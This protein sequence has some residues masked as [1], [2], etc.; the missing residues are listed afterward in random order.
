M[1]NDILKVSDK[2]VLIAGPITSYSYE[3][4]YTFTSQGASI[5]FLTPDTDKARRICDTLNDSRE[6]YKNYGRAQASAL[7]SVSADLD[8]CV[9]AAIQTI[10]GLDIYVDALNFFETTN[11]PVE[12]PSAIYAKITTILTERQRGKIVLLLDASLKQI[13]PTAESIAFRQNS[14][15][16]LNE[17]RPYLLTKNIVAH[18]LHITLSEDS[19]LFLNPQRTINESLKSINEANNLNLKITKPDNISKALIAAASDLMTAVLPCDLIL[20]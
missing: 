4:G 12:T 3:I 8:K 2:R 18:S 11:V 20:Y 9:A 7:T 6:I 17:Q 1:P 16:W 5:C 14:L 13:Q 19:L 10:N 15:D